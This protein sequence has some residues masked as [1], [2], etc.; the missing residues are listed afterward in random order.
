M[1]KLQIVILAAGKGKRMQGENP[2]VLAPLRGR[3]MI[4]HLLDSVKKAWK[5]KPII[6]VG[7]LAEMVKTELG[8]SYSYVLQS[9]QL[10]TGHAVLCA[11]DECKGAE[12]IVVLS[13][14]QPFISEE[15]IKNLI[16]K[17]LASGSEIT[18]TTTEVTDFNDWRKAFSGFG[19]VM[20]DSGEVVGI[21]E[22]KDATEEEK[23]IKEV[24]AGCY[25]FTA[26]WLWENL[27]KIKNQNAQKEYYLTDLFKIAHENN[28]KI[29]TIKIN[30]KEALG[31]N[32]K[33]E[34]EILE[35]LPI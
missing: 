9:E 19:R 3:H 26:K 15:T 21:R 2:K 17:H 28:N 8:E 6:I 24:N 7:H 14:D 20:R 35:N 29:E 34:L 1:E 18:F 31:A 5:G 10:G 22:Y 32:S 12:L 23:N 13:G 16:S 27:K 25:I 30:P 11:E 33:E 4:S